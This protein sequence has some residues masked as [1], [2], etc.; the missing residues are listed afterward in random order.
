MACTETEEY[1]NDKDMV[2]RPIADTVGKAVRELAGRADIIVLLTHLGVPADR[3]IIRVVPRLDIVF[4]G[5][6]HKKF[7]KL[8]FDQKTKTI[9]QHSGFFGDVLG[10]VTVT[11]DGGKITDRRA[12]LIR[13]TGDM[14]ASP[15][16]RA[17]AEKY[18]SKQGARGEGGGRHRTVGGRVPAAQQSVST[19][20]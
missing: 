4:G 18:L 2:L 6:H 11:W 16:V 7:R 5:H 9:L 13:I 14:P 17:I 12:R 1:D 3:E 10:V 8:D 20:Y 19:S 15:K